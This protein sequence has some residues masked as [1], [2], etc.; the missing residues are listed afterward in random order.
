MKK[1]E[2]KNEE[3]NEKMRLYPQNSTEE[4][5][6]FRYAAVGGKRPMIRFVVDEP[7]GS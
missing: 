1:N 4:H 7:R 2:E 5:F 3:K 6:T